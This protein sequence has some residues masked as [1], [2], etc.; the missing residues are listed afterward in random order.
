MFFFRL[1]PFVQD[2]GMPVAWLPVREGV[3]FQTQPVMRVCG[4]AR[5]CNGLA[6]DCASET[7]GLLMFNN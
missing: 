5:D 2:D 1:V 7:D 3:D 4:N 6:G